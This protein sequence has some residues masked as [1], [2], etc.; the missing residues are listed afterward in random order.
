MKIIEVQQPGEQV[1]ENQVRKSGGQ[2]ENSTTKERERKKL[3][4]L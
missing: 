4:R 2:V 3:T 1:V